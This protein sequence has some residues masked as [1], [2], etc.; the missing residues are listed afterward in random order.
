MSALRAAVLLF[1]FVVAPAFAEQTNALPTAITV[2][3]VTYSNVT[4][5]GVGPAS[6]SI[7]HK[8]GVASLPLEKLPPELQERFGYDPKKA[9]DYRAAERNAEAARQEARQKQWAAQATERQRQ[10]QQ[11]ADNAVA[12]VGETVGQCRERY[13]KPKSETKDRLLFEKSVFTFEVIIYQG[14][15]DYVTYRKTEITS[16]NEAADMTEDEIGK[17]LKLNG[18]NWRE[19]HDLPDAR[20]WVTADGGMMASYWLHGNILNVYTKEGMERFAAEQKVK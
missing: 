4:W 17:L 1:V 16:L 2:D 18:G 8:T 9:A 14:K 20:T 5:R 19:T 15:V 10:A 3:G 6:V 13:G 12:R 11:E 7:L